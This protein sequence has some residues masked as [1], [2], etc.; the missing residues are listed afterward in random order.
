MVTTFLR[1][2]TTKY[3]PF[4]DINRI[5][6]DEHEV[7]LYGCSV[8]P[9]TST[10]VMLCDHPQR[11]WYQLNIDRPMYLSDH[12]EW[13]QQTV[14]EHITTH[15]EPF[16]TINI[17]KGIIT[18]TLQDTEEV[19][20]PIR[21]P[22]I[23]DSTF[24]IAKYTEVTQKKYLREAVNTCVWSGIQC[25]YKQLEFDDLIFLNAMQREISV[26]EKLLDGREIDFPN[27][28]FVLSLQSW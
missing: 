24:P 9:F 25:I 10:S 4:H 20:R 15:P 2:T 16:N 22:V 26:R 7:C 21:P 13:F 12:E 8:F 1:P 14:L 17:N 23:S 6:T 28:A 18:H 11:R 3:F 27:M 5:Y 19:A